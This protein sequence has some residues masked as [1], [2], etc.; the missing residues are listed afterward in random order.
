MRG[1]TGRDRSR[2]LGVIGDVAATARWTAGARAL[3]TGR[4]DALFEDPW[5][6]ALAGDE[7][8]RWAEA[9]PAEG[10]APMVVRARFFDDFLRRA[11][12]TEGAKQVVLLGAGLDTRAFRLEWPPG[13][14]VFEVDRD[15][16]LKYK[17]QVLSRSGARS[18]CT[19]RVC[20]AGDLA[21][22]DWPGQLLE[23]GLD[24]SNMSAWLAEG[25]LFYFRT[26]DIATV[27]GHVSRLAVAGSRLA[28]DIPNR[29]VLSHPITLPWIQMQADAGAPWLGTIDDPVEYLSLFG[30][31]ASATQCGA[32]DAAYGRWPY[33]V[34]PATALELPHHW[35]VM[36]TRT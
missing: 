17:A 24:A 3:E 20:L 10:L 19:R 27:L 5:A 22:P 26:E 12:C 23:A 15:E 25:L 18:S 7:G 6:A 1:P 2:S 13:T 29:S 11:T 31:Q 36:S 34:I 9:R 30:W 16:V 33:P 8:L 14:V 4:P 32:A 35:L 21:G 28:F